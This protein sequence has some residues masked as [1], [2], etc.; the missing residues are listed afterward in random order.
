MAYPRFSY[1][2]SPLPSPKIKRGF[3]SSCFNYCRKFLLQDRHFTM[4]TVASS[5]YGVKDETILPFVPLQR[6]QDIEIMPCRSTSLTS[7]VITRSSLSIISFFPK[8]SIILRS[9]GFKVAMWPLIH[10]PTIF[11]SFFLISL[12]LLPHSEQKIN[13]GSFVQ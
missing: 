11:P 10:T 4:V 2:R 3:L 13:L 9:S 5:P 6:G 12:I 8:T 1:L 7:S